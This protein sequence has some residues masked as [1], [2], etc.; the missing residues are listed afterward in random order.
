MFGYRFVILLSVIR[1]VILPP[2]P[3]P[4]FFLPSVCVCAVDF[5]VQSVREV[6]TMDGKRFKFEIL[7]TNGKRKMLVSGYG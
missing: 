3:L 4:C 6:T 1:C 5:Q 7:M 2:I